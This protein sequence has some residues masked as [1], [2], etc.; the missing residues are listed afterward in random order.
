MSK[1][2]ENSNN[3]NGTQKTGIK[4]WWNK[5][6]KTNKMFLSVGSCCLGIILFMIVMTLIFP[7]TALS[8]EP[9]EVQIDENTTEYTIQGT[10]DPKAIVKITAP[11]LNLKNESIKVNSN[12][13][14]SYKITI[15]LNVTET[16][17][18]ITAKS[19]EKSQNGVK[20]NI[21]RPIT[22]LTIN[23]INI[24]SN[25]TTLV[26]KGKSDP[27]AD[28]KINC[29]NLNLK[30]VQL[31]ADE[32]GNFNQTINVPINL[33]EIEIEGTAKAIGKRTNTKKIT[34]TRVQPTSKSTENST[35]DNSPTPNFSVGKSK[36]YL[37]GGFNNGFKSSGSQASRLTLDNT[38]THLIITE[39]SN[40]E[41][42]AI[43]S[44][45]TVS[46]K[47]IDGVTVKKIPDTLAVFFEKNGKY[48]Q[49]AI[50]QTDG[51]TPAS[52]TSDNQQYIKDIIGS[53]QNA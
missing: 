15:P 5:K 44:K 43:E 13:S 38:D 25:A 17:V 46:Y 24:S 34:I 26:I 36:F 51:Q 50:Y 32:K 29:K 14:F 35:S 39:Y 16:D 21:Q 27:N 45:N 42:Y 10:T 37:S 53:M 47:T 19:P 9:S 18:N 33:N 1:S 2:T 4:N 23:A 8:V 40:K 28:I 20:V 3:E 7:T 41:L 11:V 49:I 12:G 31:K 52:E 48:Y 30:N 22:P 6:S